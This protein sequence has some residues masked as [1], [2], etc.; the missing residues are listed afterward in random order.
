MA[1][2]VDYWGKRTLGIITKLNIMGIE[3]KYSELLLSQKMPLNFE[4]VGLL[5][6]RKAKWINRIPPSEKYEEKYEEE[7]FF[8]DDEIY[9]KMP[10]H[11]L[12]YVSI[13]DRMKKIYFNMVKEK[14]IDIFIELQ[15]NKNIENI[16]EI[17]DSIMENND[18]NEFIKIFK[19]NKKFIDDNKK[20]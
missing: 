2:E 1:K 10:S 3:N 19:E 4:Y 13:I 9:S 18:I 14:I 16:D 5:H 7:V 6:R 20:I 12:G 15:R 17:I 8:N 11:L